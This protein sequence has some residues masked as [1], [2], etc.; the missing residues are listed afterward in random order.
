MKLHKSQQTDLDFLMPLEIL[1]LCQFDR[2]DLD[3]ELVGVSA[4]GRNPS[5]KI[6]IDNQ[7]VADQLIHSVTHFKFN[8]ILDLTTD[9]I[10]I[11]IEYYNKTDAD[12]IVDSDGNITETQSLTL[13][14]I[15]INGVDIIKSNLI[16]RLG[17]YTMNLSPEKY[18]YYTNHGFN[19]GPTHSLGMYE[20]GAWNLN[21]KIPILTN[22]VRLESFQELHEKWPN[23]EL[24][25][26][27]FNLI[28]E[29]RTLEKTI[30]ERI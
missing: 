26:A 12:T 3:L 28:S 21:M 1:D 6:W 17:N 4:N 7:L 10:N 27:I 15:T 29:I 16:Y 25:M 22:F 24:L 2:F 19:T 30:N 9:R 5:V 14:R 11:R 8:K 13:S 23:P 18:K 20:N